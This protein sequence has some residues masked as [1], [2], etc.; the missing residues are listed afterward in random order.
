MKTA[1]ASRLALAIFATF[2]FACQTASA[3]GFKSIYDFRGGTD[4][5]IPISGFAEDKAGNLYTVTRFGGVGCGTVV[6]LAPTKGGVTESVIW[7]F[8]SNGNTGDGCL[9]SGYGH[10]NIDAAGN[11]YG[12]TLNGGTSNNGVIFELSSTKSGW[13]EQVLYSFTGGLDG[14]SPNPG[15]ISDAQGNLYGSTI[16]GGANGLGAVFEISHSGGSWTLQP[17]FSV[18]DSGVKGDM[19]PGPLAIDA[20][21][22]LYAESGLDSS[23]NNG[24]V[25]EL[26]KVNGI[27]QATTLY[28]FCSLSGCSDGAGPSGGVVLHNGQLYGVNFGGG[29]S[30]QCG[31]IFE[32]VKSGSTWQ[33]NIV[34]TFDNNN[35]CA[36]NA[37]VTFDA[38]GK[39]Y[40]PTLLGGTGGLGTVHELVLSNGSW[41]DTVLYNFVSQRDGDGPDQ[42]QLFLYK[43]LLIG[44]TASGG[45][46]EVGNVFAIAP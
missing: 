38:A 42:S 5:S 32:L 26:S 12:A 6:K 16:A 28:S 11:L 31:N 25:F 45:I 17:I 41:Q 14:M 35:G 13:T 39:L 23:G 4:G 44:A 46:H 24:S 20:S 3:A 9:P 34:L 22:N 40:A 15:L 30:T 7:A 29:D 18:G 19:I 37:A 33:E 27:W 43:D 2:L 1:F 21:G 10:L 8:Q 36:P